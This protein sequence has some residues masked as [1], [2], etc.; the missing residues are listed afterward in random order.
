MPLNR[1]TLLAG[2]VL[3]CVSASSAVAHETKFGHLT[4]IDPWCRETV[5]GVFGFMRI[6]N[7]GTEDDRPVKVTADSDYV[8]MCDA[9]GIPIPAGRTIKIAP[10]AFRIAFLN[11]NSELVPN[12]NI[13]D[14]LTFEKAG[15][16]D[17][18]L[19]SRNLKD[20][21][22]TGSWS[23]RGRSPA[24]GS[25]RCSPISSGWAVRIC[26]T[27]PWVSASEPRRRLP[28][29][30]IRSAQTCVGNRALKVQMP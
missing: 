25:R 15:T 9:G 26:A 2:L 8:E 18:T 1:G 29:C 30:A 10:N 16:L 14:S 28:D 23:R 17:I 24:S 27:Y 7:N 12:T 5:G 4:I 20:G 22:G 21:E 3:T 11:T 6:T 13:K 19:K